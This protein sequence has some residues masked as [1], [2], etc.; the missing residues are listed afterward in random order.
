[1]ELEY[2]V[3]ILVVIVIGFSV[4]TQTSLGIVEKIIGTL[5]ISGAISLALFGRKREK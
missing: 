4:F 2:I 5:L 3:T 1:M